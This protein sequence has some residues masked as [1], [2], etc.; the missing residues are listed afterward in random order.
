MKLSFS[1]LFALAQSAPE[2]RANVEPRTNLVP[3]RNRDWDGSSVIYWNEYNG[4]LTG[5]VTFQE[6]KDNQH[7]YIEI[8]TKCK[9]G[10]K[11]ELSYVQLE[12]PT[13]RVCSYDWVHFTYADE[14]GQSQQ[15]N[16]I[17]GCY[18]YNS[19]A[20]DLDWLKEFR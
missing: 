16:N 3:C 11:V 7:C 1:Y 8:G 2:K 5:D 20:C 6:Y 10:V 15:T 12:S 4:G 17:C 9:G 19:S 13:S 14:N 18:P